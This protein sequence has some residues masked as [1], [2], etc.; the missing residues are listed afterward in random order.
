MSSYVIYL[1]YVVAFVAV[2][3]GVESVTHM[4]FSSRDQKQRV[5]R[6]LTLLA[7]GMK[8]E[9]VYASLVR[10]SVNPGTETNPLQQLSNKLNN[11]CRKAGPQ[12]VPSRVFSL[13]GGCTA[14]LWIVSLILMRHDSVTGIM[15]RSLLSFAVSAGLSAL[16]VAFWLTRKRASRIAALE[17]QMPLALDVVT[18]AI[19]A[20]HPVVSAVQ[21]AAEEMG[22]PI[23]SE[24]GLV[25]DETTYGYAFRDALLNF[26]R[27]SGSSDAHF[28]AV[29]VSIQ[30]E[31]GGN[32]AEILEG[33]ASVIRGRS[34]LSK[35][36]KALSSEGRASALLLSALPAFMIGG[37]FLI[38]PS[39]YT[40]KF[41]DPIFWPAVAVIMSLYLLGWVMIHRIINFRY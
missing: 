25:V 5:N 32:L 27:R 13:F 38:R 37:M 33:L 4:L 22:D 19:R 39:F 24:F 9:E 15:A 12:V 18:R 8:R 3:L 26:A 11:F 29:S 30:S 36:V 31:T 28:F 16:G 21:L 40:S 20:G 41:A 35:R 7:S 17:D 1:I 6:R 14:A 34:T 2:V 23:G 10:V